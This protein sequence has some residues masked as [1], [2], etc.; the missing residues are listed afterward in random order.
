MSQRGACHLNPSPMGQIQA[1]LVS[2]RD[3]QLFLV[4]LD[5]DLYSYQTC[6]TPLKER[7]DTLMSF[8]AESMNLTGESLLLLPSALT[9]SGMDPSPRGNKAEIKILRLLNF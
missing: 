3:P 9:H 1:F 8:G 2:N 5:R 6:S 7:H 4:F